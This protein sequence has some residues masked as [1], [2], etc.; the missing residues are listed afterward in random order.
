[1]QVQTRFGTLWD[2]GERVK[3]QQ[4]PVLMCQGSRC[5]SFTLNHQDY[6]LGGR[7]RMMIPRAWV[8]VPGLMCVCAVLAMLERAVI[9][10]ARLLERGSTP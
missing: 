9:R 1:M 2:Q 10:S 3:G 5:S 6:L 7:S 8:D 4:V